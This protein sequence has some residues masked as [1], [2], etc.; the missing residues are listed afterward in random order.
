MEQG[1]LT[2]KDLVHP[3][4]QPNRVHEV[5]NRKRSLTIEMI[6]N[7]QKDL[8]IPTESLIGA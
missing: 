2:M 7:L 8:G 3:I 5:L 4:G 1:G 6:R